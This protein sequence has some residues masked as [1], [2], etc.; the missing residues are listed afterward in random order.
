M[1]Y[2]FR[3]PPCRIGCRQRRPPVGLVVTKIL[4]HFESIKEYY[5]KVECTHPN[6]VKAGFA[7]MKGAHIE[8]RLTQHVW[9]RLWRAVL[10]PFWGA[11]ASHSGPKRTPCLLTDGTR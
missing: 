10:L 3:C 2:C 6:P 7:G 5:E 8:F 11:R 4:A 9:L 1:P